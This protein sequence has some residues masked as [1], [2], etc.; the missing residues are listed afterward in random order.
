MPSCTHWM[1]HGCR[2]EDLSYRRKLTNHLPSTLLSMECSKAV[3]ENQLPLS[4]ACCEVKA[5]LSR[6]FCSDGMFSSV[7]RCHQ[8]YSPRPSVRNVDLSETLE[9]TFV[10]AAAAGRVDAVRD[11]AYPRNLWMGQNHRLAERICGIHH[12]KSS[13]SFTRPLSCWR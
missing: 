13:L 9:C 7:C 1:V 12:S 5:I 3:V 11:R 10:L 6:V 2:L 4:D 8:V